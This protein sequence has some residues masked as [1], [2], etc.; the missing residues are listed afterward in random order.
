MKALNNSLSPKTQAARFGEAV[1]HLDGRTKEAFAANR[2]KKKRS[3]SRAE[4]TA[5]E[6]IREILPECR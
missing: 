6:Q 3:E 4:T 2:S 1:M 5:D